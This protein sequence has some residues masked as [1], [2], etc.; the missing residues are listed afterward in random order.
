MTAFS[1]LTKAYSQRA[2][3]HQ[4]LA[5]TPKLTV[6]WK[7][8]TLHIITDTAAETQTH[9]FITSRLGYCN[10]IFYGS[11]SKVLINFNTFT[12]LLPIYSQ[13]P[14][15]PPPPSS[16]TST[17]SSFHNT[18]SS[19][20]FSSFTKPFKATCYL[21]DLLH[22]HSDTLLL[23]IQPILSSPNLRGTAPSPSLSPP[24]GGYCA[25]LRDWT[26]LSTFKSPLII[27]IVII[28]VIITPLTPLPPARHSCWCSIIEQQTAAGFLQ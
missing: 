3:W 13:T 10:S 28:I 18:S 26:E 15:T 1:L 21:T 9:A 11:S 27:I 8:Y 22:H 16:R 2:A 25:N 23:R 24:S 14:E 12:I 20:S 6:K 4:G 17:D 19:K 5:N 7:V